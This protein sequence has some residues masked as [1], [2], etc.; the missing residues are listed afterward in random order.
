VFLVEIEIEVE[1]EVEVEVDKIIIKKERGDCCIAPIA[2]QT[3]KD[4][5]T[6]LN[7]YA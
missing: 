5:F 4:I 1:V 2:L 7:F 3:T 6:L